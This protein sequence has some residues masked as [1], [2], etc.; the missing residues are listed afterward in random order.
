MIC[1]I[2]QDQTM[3]R[4]FTLEGRNCRDWVIIIK[5][6]VSLVINKG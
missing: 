4:T 1:M 3:I 6:T 5:E 2:K